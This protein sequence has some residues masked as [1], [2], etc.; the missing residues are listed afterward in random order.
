[1]P[2]SYGDGRHNAFTDLAFWKG[3]YYLCFRHGETHGSLDG[4]IRI[5]RSTDMRNWE[6][7]GTCRTAGDDRDPHFTVTD[8]RLYVYFGVWD[9]AHWPGNRVPDR[10]SV[11]S[12]FASTTNGTTWSAVQGIWEPGWW[13]WRVRHHEGM[14]YGGAYTA[15]RPK[16]DVRETTGAETAPPS[17]VTETVAS[18]KPALGWLSENRG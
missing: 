15:I 9:L 3:H 4:V 17:I 6:A 11:R 10:K 1:M 16:P 14:F 8:D 5:M 7:C 13:V 18:P 12:H 2:F